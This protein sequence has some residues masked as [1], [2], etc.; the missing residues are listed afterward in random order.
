[1]K[2][3]ELP[4]SALRWSFCT[5]QLPFSWPFGPRPRLNRSCCLSSRSVKP[6]SMSGWARS[7][8]CGVRLPQGRWQGFFS[9]GWL[10]DVI[11][12]D[13]DQEIFFKDIRMLIPGFLQRLLSPQELL[14]HRHCGVLLS[15]LRLICTGQ[16]LCEMQQKI[17][18][19]EKQIQKL[20]AGH[21]DW[22]FD[23]RQGIAF[24]GESFVWKQGRRWFRFGLLV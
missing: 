21:W 7:G 24:G 18:D 12:D 22:M 11:G 16:Q 3:Y 15:P 23:S 19:Q 1:M 20:T 2:V 13:A 17:Y 8:W 6:Y 4:G 10:L 14:T 5:L 9:G